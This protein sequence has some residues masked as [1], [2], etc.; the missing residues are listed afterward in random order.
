MTRPFLNRLEALVRYQ[1][2]D[3][4]TSDQWKQFQRM[5]TFNARAHGE[6]PHGGRGPAFRWLGYDNS[7]GDQ[8]RDDGMNLSSRG[9]YRRKN[10][11]FD[12]DGLRPVE[13][14][15]VGSPDDAG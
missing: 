8:L 4:L 11:W 12:R 14:E 10:D 6:L 13:W 9:L 7:Q 15:T 1:P 2:H 5:R 3:Y